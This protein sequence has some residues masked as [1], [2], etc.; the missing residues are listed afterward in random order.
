MVHYSLP[1]GLI[2]PKPEDACVSM[3]MKNRVLM[4]PEQRPVVWIF[5]IRRKQFHEDFKESKKEA[6][7]G[8]KQKQLAVAR[9]HTA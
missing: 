2:Y 5:P 4:A 9:I 7:E 3:G 1:G 6:L 8:V